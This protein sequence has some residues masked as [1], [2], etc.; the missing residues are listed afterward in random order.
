MFKL[1]VVVTEMTGKIRSV[2][3]SRSD[4]LSACSA[5]RDTVFNQFPLCI[6]IKTK[7]RPHFSPRPLRRGENLPSAPTASAVR[8]VVTTH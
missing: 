8:H 6:L 3:S 4:F 1:R 7:I 2:A 5:D